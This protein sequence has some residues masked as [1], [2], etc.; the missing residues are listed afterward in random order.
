MWV[1]VLP[2]FER[3]GGSDRNGDG[4]IAMRLWTHQR[5]VHV[6]SS[7]AITCPCTCYI[8]GDGACSCRRTVDFG[9]RGHRRPF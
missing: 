7:T 9:S 2:S 5:H 8:E 1:D 6:H 4:E 3:V